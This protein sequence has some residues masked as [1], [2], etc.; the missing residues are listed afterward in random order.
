MASV[1]SLQDTL[2]TERRENTAAA[3]EAAKQAVIAD[4]LHRQELDKQAES[5]AKAFEELTRGNENDAIKAAEGAEKV[6]SEELT[7]ERAYAADKERQLRSDLQEAV[8]LERTR[9][10]EVH[11]EEIMVVTEQNRVEK[12]RLREKADIIMLRAVDAVTA[13]M[14]EMRV[15]CA[16][17]ITEKEA[18]AEAARV[19]DISCLEQDFNREKL[20]AESKASEA[21]RVADAER[22]REIQE[23]VVKEIAAADAARETKIN[24]L[25]EQQDAAYVQLSEAHGVAVKAAVEEAGERLHVEHREAMAVAIATKEAALL[26]AHREEAEQ[27]EKEH[28]ADIIA[29]KLNHEGE[30]RKLKEEREEALARV[31]DDAN[32]RYLADAEAATNE[33]RAS[34]TM[35]KAESTRFINTL[36]ESHCNQLATT[37][38]E[39]EAKEKRAVEEE[40]LRGQ[41]KLLAS[42]AKSATA[43]ETLRVETTAAREALRKKHREEAL[44][45]Q[46]LQEFEVGRAVAETA[47]R[48]ERALNDLKQRHQALLAEEK[49]EMYG[50]I[51]ELTAK[52][53]TELE[54][55]KKHWQTDAEGRRAADVEAAEQEKSACL[56]ELKAKAATIRAEENERHQEEISLV[57]ESTKYEIEGVRAA[58]EN[59][60]IADLAAAAGKM[61]N[62]VEEARAGHEAAGAAM[63]EKHREEVRVLREG[64]RVEIKR[65]SNDATER[66]ESDVANAKDELAA[67]LITIKAE[68]TSVAAAQ[69][70]RHQNEMKKVDDKYKAEMDRV[71]EARENRRV[72]DLTALREELERSIVEVKEHEAESIASLNKTHKVEIEILERENRDK[73]AHAAEAAKEKRVAE[74]ATLS[75]NFEKRK[76]GYRAETAE[77]LADLEQCHR[78][79]IK[80]ILDEAEKEAM[81]V[82]AA[83]EKQAEAD[84]AEMVAVLAEEKLA[85]QIEIEKLSGEHAA[86]IAAVATRA[87][88]L[89]VSDLG[90]AEIRFKSSVDAVR[91]N[92]A[93]EKA[94]SVTW[95]LLELRQAKEKSTAKLDR[96]SEQAA[97]RSSMQETATATVVNELKANHLQETQV[98]RTERDAAVAAASAAAKDAQREELEAMGKKLDMR[99]FEARSESK[100]A[101]EE[102]AERY[103]KELQKV[104]ED[105]AAKK[106]TEFAAASDRYAKANTEAMAM[107]KAKAEVD[108]D[109]AIAA[110]ECTHVNALQAERASHAE[111]V[112]AAEASREKIEAKA[113][114][115][116]E[117]I[118]ETLHE[119]VRELEKSRKDYAELEVKAEAAETATAEAHSSADELATR[120]AALDEM[121]KASVGSKEQELAGHRSRVAQLQAFVARR[122]D[123]LSPDDNGKVAASNKNAVSPTAARSIQQRVI[124]LRGMAT[125]AG[126][127]GLKVSGG[128][129]GLSAFATAGLTDGLTMEKYAEEL[130]ITLVRVTVEAAAARQD[131]LEADLQYQCITRQLVGL[132][133]MYSATGKANSMCL[134]PKEIAET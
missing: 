66:R 64:Q 12:E 54:I 76:A 60:H 29:L 119:A 31:R 33:T 100:K 39:H 84:S 88:E 78:Q 102:G 59:K 17:E 112:A 72:S 13:K 101:I 47:H 4:Q 26:K 89:R 131:H 73:E 86:K 109:V 99:L 80:K 6:L 44:K 83:V 7:R 61:S 16:A 50:T 22:E 104:T 20:F 115:R 25:R 19:K 111:D 9:I 67:S 133:V 128:D 97:K 71:V 14:A 118:E 51:A 90:N 58:A 108:L 49:A 87:E 117:A 11:Q 10:G 132:K 65:I 8:G 113:K 124:D 45:I 18:E 70:A 27:A 93:E 92:M 91:K 123:L 114:S 24:V 74:L 98:A 32:A 77:I 103:R 36:E 68:T 116:L 15:K 94:A 122:G 69:K 48:S 63:E 85:H 82:S 37:K 120:A 3:E 21:R 40:N 105:L 55:A 2:Q 56:A 130:E 106:S 79:E 30:M 5:H 81:K 53:Q 110:Q 75:S 35:A 34:I 126:V 23:A 38:E 127:G 134:G 1:D 52:H 62:A 28:T 41:A 107:A 43:I 46:E 125:G 96:V 129:T 57:E 95:H 121:L 42:T